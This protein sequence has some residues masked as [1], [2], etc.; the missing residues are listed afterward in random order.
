MEFTGNPDVDR[1]FLFSL[2]DVELRRLCLTN[3]YFFQLC[4]SPESEVYWQERIARRFPT[5]VHLP[6]GDTWRALYWRSL[7]NRQTDD[8]VLQAL[9]SMD[10]SLTPGPCI[11]SYLTEIYT[12]LYA[13]IETL[14]AKQ[15]RAW[16]ELGEEGK[17][18][19][20]VAHIQGS[21]AAYV[22]AII[23]RL[24]WVFAS[25]P[26]K[27]I[28]AITYTPWDINAAISEDPSFRALLP[29]IT[30]EVPI[31]IRI[32]E[33][34]GTHRLTKEQFLGMMLYANYST[35]D[36][37]AFYLQSCPLHYT[38][39]EIRKIIRINAV[40]TTA[41]VFYRLQMLNGDIFLGVTAEMMQGFITLA[42]WLGRN[43]RL[44][45]RRIE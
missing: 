24:V 26:I 41:P 3:K 12:Q 44:A 7:R 36:E 23:D 35:A 4:T 15:L 1:Y 27:G 21:T 39:R 17:C 45:Y 10:Y 42:R 32:G 19:L 8:A 13:V 38:A 43:Y 37:V 31:F 16:L 14:S 5:A 18:V 11:V 40:L 20:K 33:Q 28:S 34:T 22:G 25:Q 30:R 6:S 9:L 2:P 29:H